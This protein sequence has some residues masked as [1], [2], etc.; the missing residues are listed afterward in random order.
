MEAE[1]HHLSIASKETLAQAA[2]GGS[3]ASYAPYTKEY[4]G[5]S[6]IGSNNQ[7]YNGRY[8]E[9]VAYKPS[10][11]RMETPKVFL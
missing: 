9:N 4:C 2:L 5:V 11:S 8:A 1:F 7:I 6:L 10:M 3:N